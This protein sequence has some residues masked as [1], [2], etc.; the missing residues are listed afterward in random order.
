M[1]TKVEYIGNIVFISFGSKLDK[2]ALVGDV[3]MDADNSAILE[4]LL[5]KELENGKVN[6]ILDLHNIA[7]IYSYGLSIIFYAYKDLVDKGGMLK[8][9]SPSISLQ[10][11]FRLLKMSTFF[12]IFLDKQEAIDSFSKKK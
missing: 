8:I 2:G 5:E 4:T 1:Q 9:L 11:I 7:Y 6:I 12:E 10:E 3:E